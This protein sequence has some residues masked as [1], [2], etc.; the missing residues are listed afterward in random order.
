M[1]NVDDINLRFIKT[2]KTVTTLLTNNAVFL[3]CVNLTPS[4]L[5]SKVEVGNCLTIT[6][7]I[8]KNHKIIH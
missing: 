6:R 2:L 8:K 7:F 4:I 5:E 3:E 1:S